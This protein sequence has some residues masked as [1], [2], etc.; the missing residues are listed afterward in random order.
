[1]ILMKN[2]KEQFAYRL[3]EFDDDHI[4]GYAQ[5]Y[6]TDIGHDSN[7]IEQALKQLSISETELL[8]AEQINQKILGVLDMKQ[9]NQS[10][11]TYVGTLTKQ[12]ASS[13]ND[14]NIQELPTAR[15][16]VFKEL[17]TYELP[18]TLRDVITITDDEH[19]ETIPLLTY[20]KDKLS[21]NGIELSLN[22]SSKYFDKREGH[23]YTEVSDTVV[24]ASDRTLDEL[25]KE[26]F[27]N[28]CV[29]YETTLLLDKNN[30]SGLIDEQN[31]DL[32]LYNQDIKEVKGKTV[33]ESI[34]QAIKD[35]PQP[36]RR[37]VSVVMNTEHHDKLIQELAQMG[38]GALA[39]DLNKLFNITN[40]VI[41]DDAQDILVGD[42]GHGIYAKYEA[43]MYNKKKQ[44][45]RGVYQFAL[46]YVFDIKI[47]PE[48]LRIAKI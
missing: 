36:F 33:Y 21:T 38:L 34:K 41:T 25:L 23:I 9:M 29:A 19:V 45:M 7:K 17:L 31:K 11:T 18:N 27:I 26:I 8:T 6:Q 48:L 47:V 3:S 28:E 4:E 43:I 20:I 10:G 16:E 39:G 15:R 37:N 44:A 42:F 35:M 13:D 24:H 32:S 22:G 12:L 1:M 30:A 2:F 46:N 14:F 40:I 5:R